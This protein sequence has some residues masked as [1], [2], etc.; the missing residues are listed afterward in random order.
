MGPCDLGPQLGGDRAGR[1]PSWKGKTCVSDGVF[2][3]VALVESFHAA[4]LCFC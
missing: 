3:K 2:Y 1:K 4:R